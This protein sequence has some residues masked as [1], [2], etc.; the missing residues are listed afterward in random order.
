ME[1]ANQE[2]ASAFDLNLASDGSSYL[3]ILSGQTVVHGFQQMDE[4]PSA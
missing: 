4:K 3:T 2:F 1:T